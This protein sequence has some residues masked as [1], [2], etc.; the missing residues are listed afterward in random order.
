MTRTSLKL[1]VLLTV[2]AGFASNAHAWTYQASGPWVSKQ[3]GSWTVYQDGWGSPNYQ[4]QTLYAN[5][6][7]NFATAGSWTGGGVKCYA[8]A[9][10][11]PNLWMTETRRWCTSNF[12]VSSPPNTGN[13]CYD[14]CYDLW[15]QNHDD[16]IMI[17]EALYPGAGGGWGSKIASN[18]WIGGHAFDV[19][20]ANPGWNVVQFVNKTLGRT[21]GSEDLWG[22]MKWC[23]NNGR[24]RNNYWTEISFGIEVTSTN[25]WQQFTCNQ[26]WAGWGTW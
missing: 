24:L 2:L 17:L 7:S 4:Q 25:G 3:Y 11:Y 10:G 5:S 22:C 1:A 23:Y 18:V 20:Q 14:W 15:T 9:Q 26:F 6:S 8:H 13:I 16:E 21:S 12:N 19:W